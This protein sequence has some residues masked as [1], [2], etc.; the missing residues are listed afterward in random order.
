MESMLE[1]DWRF[2]SDK[3]HH[4]VGVFCSFAVMLLHLMIHKV[5]CVL[6]YPFIRRGMAL[7]ARTRYVALVE[8]ETLMDSFVKGL[9]SMHRH[10]FSFL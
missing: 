7:S 4:H 9:Y 1:L 5:Y 3:Q 10:F 2:S 8:G 6:Y